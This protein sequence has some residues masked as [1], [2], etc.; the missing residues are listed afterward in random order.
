M[1][2]FLQP[3]IA[4]VATHV[5]ISVVTHF[6]GSVIAMPISKSHN[7]KKYQQNGIEHTHVPLIA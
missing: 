7:K 6:I 3:E 4:S 2:D 1:K 5:Y